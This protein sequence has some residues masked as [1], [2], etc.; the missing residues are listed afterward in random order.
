MLFTRN[1]IDSCPETLLFIHRRGEEKI[2]KPFRS[3]P[4]G[5]DIAIKNAR[6][7]QMA[8]QDIRELMNGSVSSKSRNGL[9]RNFEKLLAGRFR[10]ANLHRIQLEPNDNS[11]ISGKVFDFSKDTIEYLIGQ[12]IT[13]ANE[14]E[15]DG[16]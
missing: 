12:G 4:T 3:A 16:C 8:V 10:I 13:D 15:I 11:D 7:K 2:L 5:A 14:L 6:D 1:G 9:H